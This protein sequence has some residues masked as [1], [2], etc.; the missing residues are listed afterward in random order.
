MEKDITNAEESI[1]Q[2]N[3]HIDKLQRDVN[4]LLGKVKEIEVCS[5]YVLSMLY[6]V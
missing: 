5:P 3:T 6:Y 2:A 1:T 4:K